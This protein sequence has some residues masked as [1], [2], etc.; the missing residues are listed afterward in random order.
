MPELVP[1]PETCG[2]FKTP[3]PLGVGG[4]K[5]GLRELGQVGVVEHRFV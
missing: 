4:E 3:T 2:G 5:L 1:R